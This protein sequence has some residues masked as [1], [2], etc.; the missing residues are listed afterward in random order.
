[1]TFK[2]QIVAVADDGQEEC[3]EVASL[4]RQEIQ[5]ET[6][7]LT[8][9]ESKVILKN[10]QTIIVERQAT[11]FLA[12]H[13]RCP[14]CGRLRH[15]KGYHPLSMRTVFGKLAV[16]SPRLYHCDCRPHPTRTFSPLAGLLPEHTTPELLFL[17]TKWAALV[18]YGL[19]VKLLEDVL[20]MDESLTAFTVR[21]HIFEAAER[22]E[23]ALG[24]EKVSFIESCQRD[25]NSLPI[26]DGPLAVGIDG[27]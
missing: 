3:R 22:M 21:R 17:E 25:R 2:I 9:A 1:M 12:F 24:E 27:G 19:T 5:P 16:R 7:G 15:L 23:N 8:L 4:E 11:D 26:P 20:P 6:F 18:S 13:Q 14:D 10:L